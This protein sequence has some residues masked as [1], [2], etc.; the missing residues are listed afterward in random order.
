MTVISLPDEPSPRQMTP[1]M[2]G[3]TNGIGAFRLANC[4]PRHAERQQWNAGV[5]ARKAEKRQA[6]AN[7]RTRANPQEN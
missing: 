1:A 7:R 2:L 3:R 4:D 6:N 5:E